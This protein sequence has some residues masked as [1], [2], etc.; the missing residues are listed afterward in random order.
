MS[1]IGSTTNATQ[2]KRP[3]ITGSLENADVAIFPANKY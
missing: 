1:I 3:I 2:A